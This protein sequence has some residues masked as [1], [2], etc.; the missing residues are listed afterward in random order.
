MLRSTMQD[1]LATKTPEAAFL[2]VMQ[3]EFNFSQRVS[4]E[5]LSTAKEMLVGEIPSLVIRPSQVRL[6]VASMQA[7]FGPPLTETDKIEVTLTVDNGF[8]DAEVKRREKREGLRRGRILRLTDEALE[9]GGVLTQ[10]DLSK[11]LG[12]DRRTII[13]DVIHFQHNITMSTLTTA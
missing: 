12:V 4:R 13:R 10:E 5:L 8:E 3:D 11:V 9:Q 7:P 2:H 1:R 6:V